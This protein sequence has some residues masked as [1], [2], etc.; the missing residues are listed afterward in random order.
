[1]GLASGLEAKHSWLILYRTR[2]IEREFDLGGSSLSYH[3][4]NYFGALAARRY[5]FLRAGGLSK[6]LFQRIHDADHGS[7]FR[8]L[9]CLDFFAFPL[10]LNHRGYVLALLIVELLRPEGGGKGLDQLF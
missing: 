8:P 2:T 9:G 7:Y 4:P 1:M 10:P 3:F 5:G 6:A